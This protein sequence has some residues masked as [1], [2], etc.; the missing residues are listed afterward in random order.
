MTLV[1]PCI[2]GKMGNTEFFEAV[3]SARDVVMA[4]RERADCRCGPAR[5]PYRAHA[6]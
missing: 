2:R 3:M 4:A 1:S 6:W 5:A